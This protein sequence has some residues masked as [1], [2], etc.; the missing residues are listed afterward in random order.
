MGIHAVLKSKDFLDRNYGR[1]TLE[2]PK[3]NE[4]KWQYVTIERM[5]GP[6]NWREVLKPATTLKHSVME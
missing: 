6:Q 3:R 2:K 5:G 1:L 4:E